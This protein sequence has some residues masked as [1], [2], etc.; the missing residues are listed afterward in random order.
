[1]T[2]RLNYSKEN[3]V[4]LAEIVVENLGT[5]DLLQY[6]A[7]KIEDEYKEDPETFHRDCIQFYEEM[8][9]Q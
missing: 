7:L 6:A 9:R 4:K 8:K 1:M 5:D 2:Q 3:M